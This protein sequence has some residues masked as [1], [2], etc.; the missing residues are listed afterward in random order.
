[1]TADEASA[2]ERSG[3]ALLKQPCNP[4]NHVRQNMPCNLHRNI[5][6][7]CFLDNILLFSSRGGGEGG[8]DRGRKRE[9]GCA[10]GVSLRGESWES[11]E[12]TNDIAKNGQG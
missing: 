6:L 12:V 4:V 2:N 11:G 1:M 8:R 3:L 9:R 5:T 7:L 10:R